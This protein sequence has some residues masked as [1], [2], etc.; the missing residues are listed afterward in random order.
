MSN[1][2]EIETERYDRWF[3]SHRAV[4]ESEVEAIRAALPVPH[5]HGLEI[6]VGTGRFATPF[7]I[8]QGVEPAAAMRRV[9]ETRGIHAVEGF[10][11]ALPSKDETFDFALM[12]TTICFVED[13]ERSCCEA[14]RVLK[15]G[16]CFVV[17]LVDLD[18]FLGREYEIQRDN[19]PFYRTAR[20]FPV[21][22]VAELMTAAGFIDL[23]F[24]QTLFHHPDEIHV[25]EP[26]MSG[27]G[28]GGFAVVAGVKD[29]D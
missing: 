24:W 27:H 8:M 20:F 11:E 15:P 4:Y 12:V 18:S 13:P 10:A 26:V 29:K 21:R 3:D 19:N 2:F 23:R 6:G 25:V 17:G 5:G 7:G 22:E 16:G 1:V 28:Q 14:W 9:A